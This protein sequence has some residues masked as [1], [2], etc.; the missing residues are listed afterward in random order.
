MG[1]LLW[2]QIHNDNREFGSVC[3]NEEYH[4]PAFLSSVLS[5]SFYKW[6]VVQSMVCISDPSFGLALTLTSGR[7]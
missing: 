1:L 4:I 5:V 2:T 6:V 7:P 3:Q